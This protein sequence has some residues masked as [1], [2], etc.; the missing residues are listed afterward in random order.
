[1][2]VVAL[3]CRHW[4]QQ[5]AWLISPLA[6]PFHPK[7]WMQPDAGESC[8]PGSRG[9]PTRRPGLLLNATVRLNQTW[10]RIGTSDTSCVTQARRGHLPSAKPAINRLEP[11]RRVFAARTRPT[12]LVLG[13]PLELSSVAA[14]AAPIRARPPVSPSKPA[15]GH[16]PV[17][18]KSDEAT[19]GRWW[20]AISPR[21]R[22]E[23]PNRPRWATG[24]RRSQ[25]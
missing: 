9:R 3:S 17:P 12:Y 5:A 10:S 8:T 19:W 6:L 7:P 18:L 24:A 16:S 14:A 25:L 23:P 2:P 22:R 21:L 15:A 11:N 1:M 20:I 4:T 13:E